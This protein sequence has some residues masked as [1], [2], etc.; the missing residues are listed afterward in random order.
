[1]AKNAEQFFG[2]RRYSRY[3][4]NKYFWT[5]RH[6]GRGKDRR[7]ISTSMHRDVWTHTHGPI[8][9]GFVVH[10]I[11][12]EPANNAPENLTLVEN[13]THCREHMCRRADKGELHFSAAARA[14]AAQWHGSEAGREWHSAHG[15]ACWDGR[16][17]DGHECAHCGKDYEVKRGCR[18]RGFCSPGCQSAARR[19]SGVDN[20]TRQCDICSG[21]FTCNKY[22]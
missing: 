22:A 13:S 16:P 6:T 8:P 14:A 2:G 20:E 18:K 21:T 11:D 12:H 5:K 7:C 4:G 3:A 17:V 15:K 1:M 9:D 19:A 10:H